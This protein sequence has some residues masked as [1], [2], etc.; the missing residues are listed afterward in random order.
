MDFNHFLSA[1]YPDKGY[2][3]DRLYADMIGQAKV[4]ERLGFQGASPSPSIT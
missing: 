4:A 1:Y 2:G 3:G